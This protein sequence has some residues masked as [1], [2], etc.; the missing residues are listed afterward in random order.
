MLF[1]W[2]DERLVDEGV[3]AVEVGVPE[4]RQKIAAVLEELAENG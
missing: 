4:L 1:C 3:G 2:I